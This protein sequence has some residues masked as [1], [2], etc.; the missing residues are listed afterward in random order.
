M[1]KLFARPE[2]AVYIALRH[3][4]T[5]R[6]KSK[7]TLSLR[8][9]RALAEIR[10]GMR[11]F[12]EFSEE[13][14]CDAGLTPA[15]HQALLAIKGMPG[16]V[17]LGALAEWLGVKPHSAVGLADRLTRLKLVAR[18]RDDKDR[19]RVCLAL[20]AGAE[21]K[22]AALSRVHRAELRRF[23]RVLAPLLAILR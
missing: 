10:H 19:R 8:D 21:K 20:T 5:R 1:R 7:T 12:L 4:S 16:P 14:A 23:S 3:K 18:I 22:L 6:V 11:Q 13:A 2:A 9:Y 17:T 15:Q